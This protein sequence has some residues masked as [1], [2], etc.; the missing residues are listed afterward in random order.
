MAALDQ[1]GTPELREALDQTGMGSHPE[2]IR[3][4]SRIGAAISEGKVIT[5]GIGTQDA[6]KT[7]A[8]VMYPSM[9]K[10]PAA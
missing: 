9:A 2:V 7:Q 10:T 3:V 4:F 1:F 8:E 6:D 5:G